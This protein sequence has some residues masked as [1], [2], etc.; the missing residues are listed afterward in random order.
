MLG[1]GAEIQMG[2]EVKLL[3]HWSLQSQEGFRPEHQESAVDGAMGTSLHAGS[4][5]QR[6]WGCRRQHVA[7]PRV[8]TLSLGAGGNV[9]HRECS[10]GGVGAGDSQVRR[11]R[12]TQR[13]DQLGGDR[14]VHGW[15]AER[16]AN[17]GSP[18][19]GE[20]H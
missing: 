5:G 2:R 9:T 4:R 17:G 10:S 3:W 11:V 19:E 15:A 13:S 20:D 16:G 1:G 18:E 12:K 14:A 7:G 6:R 8:M